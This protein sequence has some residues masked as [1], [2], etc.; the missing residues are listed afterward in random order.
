LSASPVQTSAWAVCVQEY[1]PDL[2]P[3]ASVG[4]VHVVANTPL[5]ATTSEA[6]VADAEGEIRN[7]MA[8]TAAATGPDGFIG[9]PPY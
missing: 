2:G 5:N 9:A 7:T 4:I 8:A 1:G 6:D 3:D